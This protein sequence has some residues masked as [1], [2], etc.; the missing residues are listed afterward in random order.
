MELFI[1]GMLG[2]LVNVVC[3]KIPRDDSGPFFGIWGVAKMVDEA[4]IDA[5]VEPALHV[6]HWRHEGVEAGVEPVAVFR[7]VNPTKN[8]WAGG[9]SR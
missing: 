3:Q 8:R 7:L 6:G 5:F 4:S 9:S 2:H 1:L